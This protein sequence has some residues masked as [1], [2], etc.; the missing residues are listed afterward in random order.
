MPDTSDNSR[1]QMLRTTGKRRFVSR[2]PEEGG[3]SSAVGAAGAGR[4]G[5]GMGGASR[6]LLCRE[7]LRD[8]ELRSK[9]ISSPTNFNHVSAHG[10]RGRRHAG[11]H[12]PASGEPRPLPPH[13][14]PWLP[15]GLWPS[16]SLTVS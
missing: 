15:K 12:G 1:K 7:M 14:S 8:P 3:C 9:M 5:A 2:S 11:A 4:W 10:A 6:R 16:P 13:P